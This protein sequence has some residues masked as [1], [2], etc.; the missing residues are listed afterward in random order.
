[1]ERINLERDAILYRV[2]QVRRG[3][4]NEGNWLNDPPFSPSDSLP[5]DTET[6][7]AG[8]LCP[9]ALKYDIGANC[10]L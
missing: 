5:A 6:I 2:I 10:A 1:M 3:S 8:G 9:T 4:S 7:I